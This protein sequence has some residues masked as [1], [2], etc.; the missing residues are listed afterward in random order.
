MYDRSNR[1]SVEKKIYSATANLHWN[2]TNKLKWKTTTKKIEIT[3]KIN[4][5]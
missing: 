5:Q 4:I 2:Q 3:M 1:K